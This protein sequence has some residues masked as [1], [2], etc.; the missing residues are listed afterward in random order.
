V[1]GQNFI[2]NGALV[3]LSEQNIVDCM[4]NGCDGGDMDASFQFIKTNGG[5]ETEDAYPYTGVVGTCNYDATYSSGVIV[6]G[7]VDLPAGDEVALQEAVAQIGP[8][9]VGIN[10]TSLQF[11]QSGVLFDPTCG[12]ADGID[13]AVLVVGYGTSSDGIDYWLIKNSWGTNW[14]MNG[15]F[16][17]ARNQNNMCAVASG[18]SYPTLG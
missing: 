13:H 12:G 10:A 6:T 15:Y 3:S 8:I 5:I 9:A 18:A 16:E 17:L 11:Y 7:F 4:E 14:G 2:K 1:E